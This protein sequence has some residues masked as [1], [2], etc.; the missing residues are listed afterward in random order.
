MALIYNIVIH[1]IWS[2][3]NLV[4]LLPNFEHKY[5]AACPTQDMQKACLWANTIFGK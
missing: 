1:L 3:Q 4:C 5:Q 2:G